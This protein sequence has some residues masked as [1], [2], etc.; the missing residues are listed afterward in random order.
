VTLVAERVSVR[1]GPAVL[2]HDVSLAA[3]PGEVLALVGPSGAGKSTLLRVWA[4]ELAP[5][6]GA[7]TFFGCPIGQIGAAALARTRAVLP[8]QSALRFPLR[9]L[10]V[11]LLGRLPHPGRG[12]TRRDRDVAGAALE[13]VDAAHLADRLA[14]TLSGGEQQRVQLARALAQV[15][16]ATPE[17]PRRYLLLD[18]P[19]ASLDPGH[20]GR[21]LG[22]VRWFA[23][24][25]DSTV[26]VVMHDLSAA[27]QFADR[28]A[29]VHAGRCVADGRPAE[30]LTPDRLGRCFGADFDVIPVPGGRGFAVLPRP[31]EERTDPWISP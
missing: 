15:W 17:R 4:G 6:V 3:A 24:A 26:V 19:T 22:G 16:D 1:A 7:A 27:T 25:T 14:P 8:Q 11:V 18:E 12:E 29:L 2:V 30:V 13:L 28:F 21:L 9:A 5:S 20:A 31:A 23:R 10:E